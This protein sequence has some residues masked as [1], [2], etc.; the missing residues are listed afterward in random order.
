THY[1][2]LN[3]QRVATLLEDREGTIWAGGWATTTGRLCAIQGGTTDC[4]GEDGSF[5]QGVISMYEDSGGRIWA[6]GVPVRWR[7]KPAPP[8]MY[9]VR[10]PATRINALIESGNGVIL[11]AMRD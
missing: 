1:P 2:E 4:H 9:P 7:W 6:G 8:K 5:G 3:G 10:D 11:V